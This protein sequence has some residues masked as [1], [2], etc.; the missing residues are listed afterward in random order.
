MKSL[1]QI[2]SRCLR[3]FRF[4]IATLGTNSMGRSRS[5]MT[6]Y[7][8]SKEGGKG[9][10]DWSESAAAASDSADSGEVITFFH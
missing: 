7:I 8:K 10:G 5:T 3:F 4:Q 6:R 2:R 9:L 1:G